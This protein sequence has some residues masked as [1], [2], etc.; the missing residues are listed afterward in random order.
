MPERVPAETFP[1]GEFI[2][3][4]MKARGWTLV[5]IHDRLDNDP[6]SCCSVD[7]ITYVDNKSVI[8]DGHTAA[9]LARVFG[10]DAQT[11][12]N[13]DRAWRGLQ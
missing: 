9:L 5:D 10:I 12:I 3:D 11:W 6:V 4:E 1:P 8:L 13:L 7:L 2:R